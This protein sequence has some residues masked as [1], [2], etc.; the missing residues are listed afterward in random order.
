MVRIL[1]AASLLSVIACLWFV[2]VCLADEDWRGAG[3]ADWSRNVESRRNVMVK[4]GVVSPTAETASVPPL[5]K[6]R[7]FGAPN[8]SKGE[9]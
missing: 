5:E 8:N 3:E 6:K 7:D 2:D 9:Q 4:N 1:N